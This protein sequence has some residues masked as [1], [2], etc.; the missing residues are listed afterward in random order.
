MGVRWVIIGDCL[1]LDV[2]V[3]NCLQV[4]AILFRLAVLSAPPIVKYESI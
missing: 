3:V 4:E 1:L 2:H